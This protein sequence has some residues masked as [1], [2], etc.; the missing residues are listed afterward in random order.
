MEVQQKCLNSKLYSPLAR[1]NLK[2]IMK[3]KLKD[4]VEVYQVKDYTAQRNDTRNL[5]GR[6]SPLRKTELQKQV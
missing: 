6:T 1:L 4:Q 3:P 2:R 5:F